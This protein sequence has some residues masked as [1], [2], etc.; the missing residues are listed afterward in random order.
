MG[1]NGLPGPSNGF[2]IDAA[3][4]PS[5]ENGPPM[6]GGR[7]PPGPGPKLTGPGGPYGL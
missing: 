7:A 5:E 4:Y 6:L 1:T 3:M 2:L